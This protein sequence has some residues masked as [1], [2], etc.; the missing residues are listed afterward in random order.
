[1]HTARYFSNVFARKG[2]ALTHTTIVQTSLQPL[3][4]P[5]PKRHLNTFICRV[6]S[7]HA[8]MC[9]CL[10]NVINN[11]V[12]KPLH[13]GHQCI[14]TSGAQSMDNLMEQLSAVLQLKSITD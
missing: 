14:P 6:S 2:L 8:Q 11:I 13:M 9:G 10:S 7:I 1:M 4:I 3:N 12:G 5:Q